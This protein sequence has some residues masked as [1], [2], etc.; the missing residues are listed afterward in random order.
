MWGNLLDHIDSDALRPWNLPDAPRLS[1]CRKR[2]SSEQDEGG[3][4]ELDNS[5]KTVS[6]PCTCEVTC[7]VHGVNSRDDDAHV[8]RRRKMVFWSAAGAVV[9]LVAALA[10]GHAIQGTKSGISGTLSM[11]QW[12]ATINPDWQHLVLDESYFLNTL[13]GD[14]QSLQLNV[15]NGGP[16]S[17]TE[18]GKSVIRDIDTLASESPPASKMV[19]EWH[20]ILTGQAATVQH[21]IVPNPNRVD[22]LNQF[23]VMMDNQNH[24]SSEVLAATS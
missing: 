8:D 18:A 11:K 14:P 7:P 13:M 12:D 23:R 20:S 16:T 4:R 2:P 24:L 21:N 10:V 3:G 15:S 5:S 9:V 22:A 19:T 1:Q 17:V 6:I